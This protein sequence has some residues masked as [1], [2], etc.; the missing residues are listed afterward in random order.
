MSFANARGI[1]V[2]KVIKGIGSG[3]NYKRKQWN[4]PD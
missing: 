3:L 2:D 1:I 4:K